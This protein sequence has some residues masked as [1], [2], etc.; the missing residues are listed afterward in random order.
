MLMMQI[1]PKDDKIIFQL[2]KTC[3]FTM[4]KSR[5]NLERGRNHTKI[6]NYL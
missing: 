6:L 4:F 2:Q 1:A 5:K 3:N